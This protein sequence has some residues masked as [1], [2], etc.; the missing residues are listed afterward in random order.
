MKSPISYNTPL[1]VFVSL[2]PMCVYTVLADVVPVPGFYLAVVY[3]HKV[4][5]IGK[6]CE[7]V[8]GF[9]SLTSSRTR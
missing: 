7:C 9:E 2:S 1:Q 4:F 3:I 6:V 8:S 5:T